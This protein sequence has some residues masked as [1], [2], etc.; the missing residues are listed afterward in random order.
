[1][2]HRTLSAGFVLLLALSTICITGATKTTAQS[3]TFYIATNGNNA[4][5]GSASTPWATIAHA[6]EN[7]PDGSTILVRSGE[8]IGNIRL[9]ASFTKGVTV[10]A[11]TP[12]QARLRNDDQVVTIYEGQGIA[13]EG[14]DI[15]HSGAGAGALVIHIQDLRGEPGCSD[16][17]CVSNITLR[18]NIIHDSYNNDLLKINNGARNVTVSGNIFY[19]QSGSDEHI[20]INSVTDVVVQDNVFMNDFAGSGRTNGNDTSAY[21]VIKD[22]NEDDDDVLGSRNITVRRNVFLNW[23]GSSG[24]NFVLIGEDGK[25][26]HEARDVLVEN[27]L[28]LGNAA[29]VMRSPF[30]VKGARDITFRHNTI[31][32]DLPA[33]AFAMRLNV[34]GANPP[35]DNIRFYNNIWADPTGTMNTFSTTPTGE[36]NAFTLNHNLY[37]NSDKP[38]P[39]SPAALINMDDDAARVVADPRLGSQAGLILPRWDEQN[40]RFADGSTT[41]RQ[42]FERLVQRYGTPAAGSAAFDQA[43][44]AQSPADDILSNPRPRNGT[45]DV[46]ALEAQQGAAP[47]ELNKRVYLPLLL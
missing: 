3:A 41:I 5:N 25:P 11:E 40:E 33:G 19:N 42:A 9:D 31:V 26:Y 13:L 32:G 17:S 28:M 2:A 10:R 15:A 38:L 37:W 22:S 35:N 12:Y 4:G 30:G 7:V 27:N 8:Y 47:P 43:L 29:N 44:A 34:E 21:V 1:M 45:P 6:V 39:S 20:D 18:N 14:F 24:S 23:E 46:G 36:T 16:G